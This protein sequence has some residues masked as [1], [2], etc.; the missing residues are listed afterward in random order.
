MAIHVNRI[1]VAAPV[2][3]AITL[4]AGGSLV[5]GTTY[6]FRVIALRSYGVGMP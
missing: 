5:V 2:L 6:Y 3:N 4:G 1:T